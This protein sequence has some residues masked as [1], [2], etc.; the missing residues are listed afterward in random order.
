MRQALIKRASSGSGSRACL[1]SCGK[2]DG[3]EERVDGR[4]RAASA[5]GERLSSCRCCALTELLQ[6]CLLHLSMASRS[7]TSSCGEG[8]REEMGEG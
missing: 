4:V 7:P 3:E 2:G 5:Q 6:A 8:E 1:S